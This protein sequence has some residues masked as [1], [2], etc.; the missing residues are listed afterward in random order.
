[1]NIPKLI[2][3]AITGLFVGLAIS[4]TME[5]DEPKVVPANHQNQK[6]LL[7]VKEVLLQDL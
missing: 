5:K 1:M 4:R 2:L 7:R 3:S 6:H